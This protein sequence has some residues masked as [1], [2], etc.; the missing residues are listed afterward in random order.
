MRGRNMAGAV[1][2]GCAGLTVLAMLG[3][4]APQAAE[5]A[6]PSGQCGPRPRS[7]C[8]GPPDQQWDGQCGA[9]SDCQSPPDRQRGGQCGPRPR[10][11]CQM[12]P[13][14]QSGGQCGPRSDCQAPP[15]R[16]WGGQCGA[17]SDCEMQRENPR[18]DPASDCDGASDEMGSDE[19]C[20]TSGPP[21]TPPATRPPDQPATTPTTAVQVPPRV[22]TEVPA[23]VAGSNVTRPAPAPNPEAAPMGELPR[24]GH[25]FARVGSASA[26]LTMALGG[27]ALIGG[28]GH[29]T[30]RRFGR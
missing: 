27:L 7:D 13:E 19:E 29:R 26:G 16:Q 14:E 2:L 25:S 23:E 15:D 18:G 28:A 4:V 9:R 10:S 11:G 6:S 5:A 20:Y 24:T 12:P 22:P 1:G 30:R 8:Q 17:R 21:D 3:L